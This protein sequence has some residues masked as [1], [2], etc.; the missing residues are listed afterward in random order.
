MNPT[1][2]EDAWELWGWREAIR[3][4]FLKNIGTGVCWP[5]LLGRAQQAAAKASTQGH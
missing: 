5:R 1:V 2:M 4:G 3:E